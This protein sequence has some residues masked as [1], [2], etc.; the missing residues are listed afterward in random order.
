M[1][2]E[3]H[4]AVGEVVFVGGLRGGTGFDE[5]DGGAGCCAGKAGGEE[6]SCWAGW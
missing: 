4:V 1:L 5:Q 3:G 2:H 6:R